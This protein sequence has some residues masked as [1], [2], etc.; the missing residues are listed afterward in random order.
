[1]CVG[2]VLDCLGSVL[3]DVN[4][5][6]PLS[7]GRVWPCFCVMFGSRWDGATTSTCPGWHMQ[8]LVIRVLGWSWSTTTGTARWKPACLAPGIRFGVDVQWLAACHVSFRGACGTCPAWQNLRMVFCALWTRTSTTCTWRKGT[9]CAPSV[10]GSSVVEGLSTL[11]ARLHCTDGTSPARHDLHMV[12]FAFW[13]RKATAWTWWKCACRA[14]GACEIIFG[15]GSIAKSGR[16]PLP[17]LARVLAGGLRLVTEGYSGVPALPP[18]PG[19]VTSDPPE[20][21]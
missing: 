19:G 4:E 9:C 3:R 15:Q 1:M 10:C 2:L 16:R 6:S 20:P 5:A 18:T 7:A 17:R 12:L 8:H 11:T 13:T 21:L 14:Q